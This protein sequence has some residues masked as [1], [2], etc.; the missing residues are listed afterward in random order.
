MAAPLDGDLSLELEDHDPLP[1][2]RGVVALGAFLADEFVAQELRLDHSEV[3]A[4]GLKVVGIGGGGASTQA[5]L[6]T[7]TFPIKTEIGVENVTSW[8][9]HPNPPPLVFDPPIRVSDVT[10][11]TAVASVDF[12]RSRGNDIA[13]PGRE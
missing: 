9:P 1:A 7:A 12:T 5:P 11:P 4:T 10:D 3:F 6:T 8:A 13:V 2:L